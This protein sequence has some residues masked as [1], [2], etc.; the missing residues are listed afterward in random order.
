MCIGIAQFY[1]KVGHIFAAILKTLNPEYVFTGADGIKQAC[2][3]IRKRGY[4]R[5]LVQ[6]TIRG[7]C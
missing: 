5:S 4:S 2:F 7:E 1:V 6:F 3:F